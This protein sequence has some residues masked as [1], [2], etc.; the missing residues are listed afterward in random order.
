MKKVFLFTAFL[1]LS[2]TS[3]K[4]QEDPETLFDG[5]L[6]FSNLGVFVDPG[7]QATQ[8]AGENTGYFL[9]RGGLTF[10][11]KISIGG[12]YGQMINDIR[13]A[14]FENILPPRA[15]VDSYQAGGFIEYT[16]QASK[17]IHFT[18]PLAFGIMELEVDEEGRDF[19]YEETKTLFVEPGA[20]VEVNLHRFARLHAGLGYRVMTGPIEDFPGVPEAGN[21]LTFQIGLKMGVF[22]FKQ[23]KN[24]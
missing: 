18:F 17:M 4:A 14:S 16:L 22:N 3:L 8:V 15:H 12:F 13:P 1:S 24:Q 5:K 7:F 9:F 11:D 20:Q 21:A 6:S 2:L 10:G 19:D 23:L